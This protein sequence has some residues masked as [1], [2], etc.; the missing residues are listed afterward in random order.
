MDT[1]IR[2][3]DR[4][5]VRPGR[6]VAAD[7]LGPLPWRKSRA[8]GAGNCVELAPV[9]DGVVAVRH[10]QDPHGPALIYSAAEIAAFVAGAKDGEFDDLLA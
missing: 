10:S 6:S 7:S 2:S 9:A 8:S 3:A 1:D 5:D 4:P